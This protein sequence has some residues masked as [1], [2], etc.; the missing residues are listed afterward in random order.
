MSIHSLTNLT[1]LSLVSLFLLGACGH[2]FS[3][4]LNENVLYDPRPGNAVVTVADS[5]LQSCINVLMRDREFTDAGSIEVLACPG[6]EIT[7][8]AGIEQLVNLRFVDLAGNELVNMDGLQNLSRLSSVNAPGN[9]L[10]DVSALIR[11]RTLTSA[12]LTGNNAIPCEQLDALAQR[13]NA[14]LLRPEQCLP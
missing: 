1:T 11:N 13:L 3:V 14:G 4:S 10:Q 5:G 6:L 12:V 8:L 2:R 7:S 9:R